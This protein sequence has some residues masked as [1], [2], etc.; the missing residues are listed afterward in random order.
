MKLFRLLIIIA[1][2]L[3]FNL[4]L[5]GRSSTR[6]SLLKALDYTIEHKDDYAARRRKEITG[7]REEL[8]RVSSDEDRYNIYR[9]LFSL[10]RVYRGDSALWVSE[11]RLKVAKRMG[12]GKKINSSILNLAESYSLAGDYHQALETLDSLNRSIL[13]P[14]H[15]GYMHIVYRDTY[16]RM[17]ASDGVQSHRIAYEDMARAHRDTLLAITSDTTFRYARLWASR[18][19]DAGQWK[20]SLVTLKSIEGMT[21]FSK[22][23]DY[24]MQLAEVYHSMGDSSAELN[25]LVEASIIDLQNGIRDYSALIRLANRLAEEGDYD[26]A[27]TYIR[28]AL[29]DA[30]FCNATSR[31]QE[32][33]HSVPII[34]AA[35]H[36]AEREQIITLII[37]CVIALILAL[38]LGA[39]LWIA[40]RRLKENER[41]REK[42]NK[43]NVALE[44]A[45]RKIS[46]ANRVRD[47]Y[48][49]D[50][51]DAYSSYINRIGLLRKNIRQ[52]LKISDY[53]KAAELVKSDKPESAELKELY[54]RF[55]NIFLYLYPDFIASFNQMVNEN[56]RINPES[57][58]LTPE[59]RVLALMKIGVTSSAKIAELLHYS[60]QTVYNYK[61][62]I[63]N[64]LIISKDEFEKEFLE[65]P[66]EEN[67]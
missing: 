56:M 67:P 26:R 36:A 6:D 37:L 63:R 15:A 18:L 45:N 24:K 27:Y 42:L 40:H 7:L 8:K 59:L 1:V 14:Y 58:S 50:F 43:R 34:D 41:M 51:F 9:S 39:T 13:E 16:Q 4:N 19:A 64:S 35:Y 23:G 48:I 17:S 25:A 38:G 61:F 2:I 49:T 29:E 46:I 60:P 30:Y 10:Y 20:E 33:L 66:G 22:K 52:L 31:T 54:T 57:A 32:I 28:C 3:T 55:D 44:E 5:E 11:Q 65:H 47:R 12:D 21:E 53:K 62:S